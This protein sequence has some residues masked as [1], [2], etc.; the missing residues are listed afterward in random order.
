MIVDFTFWA[1]LVLIISVVVNIVTIWYIRKLLDKF[2][3]ISQNL[4]DLVRFVGN[5]KKHLKTVFELDMYYGDETL[6]H[7]LAHTQTLENVLE[8]YEDVYS[9]SMPLDDTFLDEEEDLEPK[10]E[11]EN[12]EKKVNQENVFYAGTRRRDR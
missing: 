7:L 11:T 12:A 10:E 2:L 8:E 3:F 1:V 5:Y 6:Q 4:G 9:I